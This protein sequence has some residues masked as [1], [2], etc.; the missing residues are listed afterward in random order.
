[1]GGGVPIGTSLTVRPHYATEILPGWIL[2]GIGVGLA[3]PPSSAPPAQDLRRTRPQRA[4]PWCRWAVSSAAS[5]GS[6]SWSSWW[7]PRTLPPAPWTASPTAGGGPGPSLSS[8]SSPACPWWHEAARPPCPQPDP[9]ASVNTQAPHPKRPQV[10]GHDANRH[11]GCAT[12]R[13]SRTPAPVDILVW[14]AGV[15]VYAA[16]EATGALCPPARAPARAEAQSAPGSAVAFG[17]RLT[18]AVP[19]PLRRPPVTPGLSVG[20]RGVPRRHFPESMVA[21]AM[22][23]SAADRAWSRGEVSLSD[24]A[25]AL[26]PSKST[27]SWLP[28]W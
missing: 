18:T 1:M 14:N 4:A 26:A 25:S 2:E 28:S 24:V 19:T 12:A 8:R 11:E 22:S 20:S 9:L 13:R 6:R 3:I 7:G 17:D 27:A 15:V 21:A 23:V 10:G 16:V 5:S